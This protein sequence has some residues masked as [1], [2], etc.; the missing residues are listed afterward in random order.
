MTCRFQ[1]PKVSGSRCMCDTGGIR[2]TTPHVGSAPRLTDAVIAV[3]SNFSILIFGFLLLH[4]FQLIF[5]GRPVCPQPGREQ[6]VHNHSQRSSSSSGRINNP[7]RN[8]SS[9]DH[10]AQRSMYPTSYS[11]C[12]ASPRVLMQEV[13]PSVQR[14][15]QHFLLPSRPSQQM[16]CSGP[17][18]RAAVGRG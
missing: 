8:C 5:L 6:D 3:P 15:I 2:N 18:S 10:Q 9:S 11:S 16:S 17:G 7:S 12:D 13:A 14:P 4:L 1:F